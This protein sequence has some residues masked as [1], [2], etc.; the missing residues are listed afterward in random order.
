MNLLFTATYFHPYVSGLSDYPLKIGS[1]LGKKHEV[2]VLTFRHQSTLPAIEQYNNITI[3]RIPPHLRILKGMIN[4]FYPLISLW[5]VFKSDAVFIN[6]PQ[7]EGK[8]P[9]FWGWV[10]RKKVYAIYHCELSFDQGFFYKI[11]EIV[12]HASHFLICFFSKKIIV[13][14]KDYARSTLF[15]KFFSSKILEVLPPVEIL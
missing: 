13:Y 11:A 5:H 9:A 15:L 3:V 6:I 4:L 14:T 2:S 8:F 1:Y 7:L 10:L 12:S